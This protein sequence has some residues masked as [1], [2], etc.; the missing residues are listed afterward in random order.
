MAQINSEDVL[1]RE[2]DKTS[3]NLDECLHKLFDLVG[4]LEKENTLIRRR[5]T[6]IEEKA[7]G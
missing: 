3:W 1:I 5:L 7:N 6:Q 2:G 4:K